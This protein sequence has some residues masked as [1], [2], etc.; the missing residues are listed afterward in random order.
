LMAVATNRVGS[1]AITD[2]RLR[3]I[4]LIDLEEYLGAHGAVA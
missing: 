3:A 1:I 4:W 2:R